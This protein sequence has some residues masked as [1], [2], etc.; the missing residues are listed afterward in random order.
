M[1][2]T[3]CTGAWCALGVVGLRVHA[4]ATARTVTTVLA[5]SAAN[6]FL[7]SGFS[8]LCARATTQQHESERGPRAVPAQAA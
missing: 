8:W 1:S 4:P 6:D 2:C 5:A 3:R 7:H